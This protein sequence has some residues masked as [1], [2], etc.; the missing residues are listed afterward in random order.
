LL[1]KIIKLKKPDPIFAGQ[2]TVNAIQW[3]DNALIKII[4][5]KL[6]DFKLDIKEQPYKNAAL[7]LLDKNKAEEIAMSI[8]LKIKEEAE[9]PIMEPYTQAIENNGLAETFTKFNTERE[10]GKCVE[11]FTL[12]R[13]CNKIKFQRNE[14]DIEGNLVQQNNQYQRVKNTTENQFEEEKNMIREKVNGR[15]LDG[16][17]K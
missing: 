2:L 6:G 3:I 11:Y 8:L 17:T 7:N 1:P 5:S 14:E 12:K 15:E 9:E 4:V 13:E 10:K 16:S